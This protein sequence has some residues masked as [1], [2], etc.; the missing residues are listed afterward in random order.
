VATG[1]VM[2]ADLSRRMGLITQ[3]DADR[4]IALL[5]RAR[6][7]VAPPGIA[8]GVLHELMRVDK[9]AEGGKL[10]FVLLD[11]IGV[12]S[13]RADVPDALLQQALALSPA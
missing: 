9:K 8:P 10:R 4:I 13:V 6:L 1:M 7:P 3:A 12:A 5:K 11:A 2:A